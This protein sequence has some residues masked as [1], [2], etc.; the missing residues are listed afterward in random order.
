MVQVQRYS[1]SDINRA[2][3]FVSHLFDLPSIKCEPPLIGERF[4][5][6]F[7]EKNLHELSIILQTPRFFPDLEPAETLQLIFNDIYERVY[8]SSLQPINCFIDNTD[9]TFFNR[10]SENGVVDDM[11][12]RRKLH[13][14]FLTMFKDRDVRCR[15]YPVIAI[16]HYNAVDRYIKE[17]FNRCEY[18]YNEIT[19][20][21][22]INPDA[23]TYISLIKVVIL[24]R[25]FVYYQTDKNLEVPDAPGVITDTH[26]AAE[27]ES[28]NGYTDGVRSHTSMLPGIPAQIVRFAA[29]SHLH[30]E[31]VDKEDS[32]SKL[33]FIF[34]AMF[35]YYREVDDLHRGIEPPEKSWLGVAKHNC[36]YAGYDR[37]M[38]DS[39]YLIAKDN[40]W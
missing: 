36:G 27:S 39:L 29:K 2:K 7:I 12:R 25:S 30:A 14:F 11:H 28:F 34:C 31:R 17:V 5:I 3:E 40:N 4:I 8:A 13:D 21:N 1:E 38:I 22:K 6:N 19:C 20:I 23:D 33:V 37:N 24:L 9:L 15:M 10:L 16:F 35:Q 18:I 32:V 26:A